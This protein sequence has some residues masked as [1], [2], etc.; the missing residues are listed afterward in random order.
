MNIFLIRHGQTAWNQQARLQGRIDTRLNPT[1]LRQTEL[2]ALQLRQI[3]LDVI[4][5]SNLQRARETAASINRFHLVK[6][7][8]EPNLAEIDYGLWEGKQ[9][10]EIKQEYTSFVFRWQKDPV[11]LAP[12]GGE[13]LQDLTNR[14]QKLLASITLQQNH[15]IALVTHAGVLKALFGIFM[16][17]GPES[18]SQFTFANGSISLVQFSPEQNHY[19]IIYQNECSHL[20]TPIPGDNQSENSRQ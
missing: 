8:I 12:P 19:R 17:L 11:H 3:P 7:M 15:N 1:G 9:W 5:C 13:S 20:T 6:L 14:L 18:H 16:G 10:A 2:V 4:Y